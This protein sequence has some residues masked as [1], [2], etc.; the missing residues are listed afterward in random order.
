MEDYSN[1]EKQFGNTLKYIQENFNLWNN[2]FKYKLGEEEYDEFQ[3]LKEKFKQK[4]E[5][6]KDIKRFS[7]PIIGMISSGKSSFLN[8]L[9]GINCLEK[10]DDITTKSVVIIRH[11]KILKPDERYIYS[12]IIKERCEGFYNFEIDEK[13]QSKDLN[14]VI[15]KRNDLIK[16][17]EEDKLKK[18]DFFLIIEANIP[19]F[20]DKNSIYGDFF[21]FLDLPGLDE[22]EKES[23]SQK[24]SNFFK[25]YILPKLACN[26]LFSI[27]IFD[28]GKYM[29]G[30]N[31]IISKNYLDTYFPQNYSNSFFILNKTDLMDD[32]KKEKKIFEE[33]MLKNKL[34]INLNDKTIHIHYLSCKKL[35]NEIKRFDDFQS[36]LKFL[37]IE[38]S[39]Q[40]KTNLLIYLK[41]NLIKE[42]QIDISNVG[43]IS[44]NDVQKKIFLEKIKE[45][46]SEVSTFTRYLSP[47]EYLNYSIAFGQKI[48][49]LKIEDNQNNQV[50]SEKY[51]ELFEDFNKSFNDSMNYFFNIPNDK[52]LSQ[53]IKNIVKNIDN[54]SKENE[55]SIVKTQKY[56]N[57]LYKDLSCDA[58][59]SIEK[60][61][62][63]NPIVEELYE[64]GKTLKSFENLKEEFKLIDFFIKKDKK[65][66]IPLFGGYSTGKS[67]TLNCIIG[68]KILPE[69]NQVTTRKIVV[70]RNCDEN[71]YTIS[72]TNF[73]KTNEDYFCFE[74]GEIIMTKD[75]SNYEDIYEFLKKENEDKSGENM[76]YLLTAPIL[77]F[78]N[79]NIS[80]EILNKIEL[81]DFPGVDV[82]EK[83]VHDIFHNI[84][85]LSDTFIFMNE[86]NLVKNVENIQTIKKIVNRIE[87]RRFT[88]DYNSCLFVLNKADKAEKNIDKNKKKKEFEDILF[89]GDKFNS[90]SDFFKSKGKSEISVSIFCSFYF[91]KYLSF[92]NEIKDFEN[93]IKKNIDETIDENQG[94]ENFDLIEQLEDKFSSIIDTDFENFQIEEVAENKEY[95][96]ILK[97]CLNNKGIND[98]QIMNKSENLNNIIKYY[99][100]MINHLDKNQYYI[101]SRAK[102]F[103]SDL[104]KKFIIAKDMTE[105][106]YI[107]KI[108]QF[109]KELQT[110]FILL[111]QNSINKR[112]VNI[113][114]LK[115]KMDKKLPE[116]YQCYEESRVI[117]KEKID[118]VFNMLLKKIDDL[119]SF[120][121][122]EKFPK[123]QLKQSLDNFSEL[124]K[125]ETKILDDFIKEHFFSLQ[126]KLDNKINSSLGFF[127]L[128]AENKKEE[129]NLKCLF[130]NPYE[131]SKAFIFKFLFPAIILLTIPFSLFSSTP[132]IGIDEILKNIRIEVEEQWNSF[133]FKSHKILINTINES[134]KNMMIIYETQ[135]SKFNDKTIQNLFGKF[136]EIIGD[137][138]KEENKDEK[139][140]D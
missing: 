140:L 53:R 70:I 63:L 25:K 47:K 46:K 55:D 20:S 73:V 95:L 100:N 10:D 5:K 112:V 42:F 103:F 78:K 127:I 35:T 41:E 44:P 3:Y 122:D 43:D 110:I 61:Q 124:Y 116:I 97:I 37:L 101:D 67:S 27:L 32:E 15:K 87:N 64:N 9:L 60:F 75:E 134:Y 54:L 102:L 121:K 57:L 7:I 56:I 58:K 80:K 36:F 1:L 28:A 88:F 109:I 135:M 6:F 107:E 74:D 90:F 123:D 137:K 69:G 111:Q 79:L 96:S 24:S 86:C 19:L 108:K 139:K 29:R 132:E 48:E 136:I 118:G 2:E 4:Y 33:E 133:Y 113:A 130:N 76:F 117:I 114:D 81:I 119:I 17:S 18:E 23:K 131:P 30:E 72:K 13:T 128:F 49:E 22:D 12:A 11:N 92:Y 83:I 65:L 34:N 89:Q 115:E 62:K 68:K 125:K 120:T 66:R 52:E 98:K 138:Y 84:I 21:E 38:G 94:I 51:K 104:E 126:Y 31:P 129:Y 59:L 50:K 45:L 105:K 14:Q 77:L 91:L 85:Q 93:Y 106:Q 39:K 8:F 71:K 26:S 40:K 82:D 16:N 99:L